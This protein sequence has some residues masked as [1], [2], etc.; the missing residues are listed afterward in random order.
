MDLPE[1]GNQQNDRFRSDHPEVAKE[2]QSAADTAPTSDGTKE[3]ALACFGFSVIV[4]IAIWI[5][6]WYINAL[7]KPHEACIC[8]SEEQQK[9]IEVLSPINNHCIKIRYPSSKDDQG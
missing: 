8:Y 9:P 1:D 2:T 6:S 5:V 4:G 3:L 7:N